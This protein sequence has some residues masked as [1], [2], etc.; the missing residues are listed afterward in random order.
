MAAQT[1]SLSALFRKNKPEQKNDPVLPMGPR[2]E[3][4]QIYKPQS[5]KSAWNKPLE[6]KE[7][8]N[9]QINNMM[10]SGHCSKDI[11]ESLVQDQN[12]DQV[13]E[14]HMIE[15][16]LQRYS[17]QSHLVDRNSLVYYITNL[18]NEITIR[19]QEEIHFDI[20]PDVNL[21]NKFQKKFTEVR[22]SWNNLMDL[23]I[24][25]FDD[26][27]KKYKQHNYF[28]LRERLVH[29]IL[30][31]SLSYIIIGGSCIS[32]S[33]IDNFNGTNLNLLFKTTRFATNDKGPLEEFVSMDVMLDDK[34]TI[35]TKIIRF[36]KVF[37]ESMENIS[38]YSMEISRMNNQHTDYLR[39]QANNESQ[40]E[41]TRKTIKLQEKEI[42]KTKDLE[43]KNAVKENLA[44]NKKFLN[45]YI[46]KQK[47]LENNILE[48]INKKA[49]HQNSIRLIIVQTFNVLNFSYFM[50]N[51]YF[52]AL[53]N[54][55][56][57]KSMNN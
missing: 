49:E 46:A 24:K 22:K 10:V 41:N 25:I 42:E 33:G 3:S 19:G 51:D 1:T 48:T 50:H 38:K 35:S 20:G 57:Q 2:S 52:P 44:T 15:R 40:I 17:F 14:R 28:G 9:D 43:S 21:L 27:D 37:P 32:G 29:E 45:N 31:I 53:D 18:K 5:L 26:I 11:G 30:N 7:S 23:L 34:P 13:L 36:L 6:Y 56:I 16:K 47:E 12:A 39:E 54:G 4:E 8:K 55:L